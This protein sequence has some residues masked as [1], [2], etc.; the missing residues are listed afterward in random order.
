[1]LI[2]LLTV[3]VLGNPS[4]SFLQQ[5]EEADSEIALAS[6]ADYDLLTYASIGDSSSDSPIENYS[7][8]GESSP[9][10]DYML[11]QYI[12]QI[13]SIYYEYYVVNLNYSSFQVELIVILQDA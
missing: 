3:S 5:D 10:N 9:E 8:E 1:M 13:N 6:E 12:N 7:P 11:Q 2:W 4:Q